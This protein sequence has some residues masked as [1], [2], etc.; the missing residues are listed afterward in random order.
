MKLCDYLLSSRAIDL[1]A[2]VGI[3]PA[4]LSQIKAGVRKA[5]ESVAI[6][7]E[8]ETGGAVTCE[9][10][11]PD[12]VEHWSYIRGTAKQPSHPGAQAI[13]GVR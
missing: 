8:R 7:I 9:E 12:L 13:E 1:A 2:R 6:L 4:Y 11:R 10:L 3:S 5:S